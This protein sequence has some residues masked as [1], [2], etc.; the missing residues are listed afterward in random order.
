MV[1]LTLLVLAT[2]TV[3]SCTQKKDP[4]ET[5]S[6]P[7]EISQGDTLV[8]L[9]PLEVLRGRNAI[10]FQGGR[11]VGENGIYA[12]APYCRLE[13]NGPALT[14][15]TI[16]PQHFEVTKVTYDD[17]AQGRHADEQLSTTY[18]I[19]RAGKGGETGRIACGWPVESAKPNFPTAEEIGAAL[20]G[21][22]SI[23]V[24]D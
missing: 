15:L 10:Y 1:R 2:A 5:V 16:Q 18:V 3:A 22:F 13:L 11:V 12:D 7:Q 6:I 4:Y 23:E 20:E 21:Y 17:Q 14:K 9:K 19:L 8:L 24:P